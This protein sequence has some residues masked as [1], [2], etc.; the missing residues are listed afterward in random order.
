MIELTFSRFSPTFENLDRTE[1][2]L[3]LLSTNEA[4]SNFFQT[5]DPSLNLS[6]G[7]TPKPIILFHLTYHMATLIT[8]PSF[9]KIFTSSISKDQES[10]TR[11]PTIQLILRSLFYA[12]SSTT[13]LVQIYHD[14]HTFQ[15]AN[16]VIIHH[17]LSAS[18]VHL[19]N[20]T[21]T[22]VALKRRSTR[23]LRQSFSLLSKLARKW[24][25]RSQ[26]SIGVIK[27]LVHRWGSSLSLPPEKCSVSQHG[28]DS[29]SGNAFSTNILELSDDMP[30][31]NNMA[32]DYDQYNY[33]DIDGNMDILGQYAVP[34]LHCFDRFELGSL[35]QDI[36][37]IDLFSVFEGLNNNQDFTWL[38][39]S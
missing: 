32:N 39:D 11:T 17:L 29:I 3:L 19:M 13:R 2:V 23:L 4:L 22:N 35:S 9:L 12:A 21:A 14:S 25:V 37:P 30:Q 24:P 20:S 31:I 16:P 28:E 38:F 7:S 8:M 26:K 36:E 5:R 18:I 6:K 33:V 27:V 1:Q 10:A 15:H 34:D